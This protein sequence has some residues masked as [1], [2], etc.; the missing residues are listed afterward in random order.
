MSDNWRDRFKPLIA[1]VLAENAGKPE[2]ELRQAL[3]DAFP[4]GPR[5]Y[6][7]YKVWLSEIQYQ[8]GLK[9]DKRIKKGEKRAVPPCEG[10]GELF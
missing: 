9:K 5:K 10:Q 7:P 6:W 3:R 4:Q 8:R 1:Q 2:G